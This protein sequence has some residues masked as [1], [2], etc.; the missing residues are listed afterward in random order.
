MTARAIIKKINWPDIGFFCVV[1]FILQ[2][3]SVFGQS[4]SFIVSQFS[5]NEYHAG[6]QNWSVDVD[7]QGFVYVGNNDGLLV[8]N[9][10][11]WE[12]YQ[13]PGQSIVR[14]VYA[15]PDGRVYVGSYEEFG[16]WK[17][18]SIEGMKYHSLK[19]LLDNYTFHNEE[20]WKIVQLDDLIYFQ[21]FSS[22]FVYDG[23]SVENLTIPGNLIFLL[24][25]RGHLYV[26]AVDGNLYEL[27]NNHFVLFDDKGVLKGTEVKTVLPFESDKL[28]IGTTSNGVFLY[29]G[30]NISEWNVP[31]NES[32]KDFQI[33][34]AVVIGNQL[35][36]GTIVDGLYILDEKGQIKEHLN[37]EN[38]LQNNTILA[39]CNDRFGNLWLGLDSGIDQVSFNNPIE[40]YLGKGEQLGAVYTAALS[41]DKLY[42][43]T[44]RGIF[45]Y[46]NTGGKYHFDRFLD[47]SQ[48]Q[49]WQ[50]KNIDGFL[51]VGH[52]SGTFIIKNNKLKKIS[53]I[54]GGYSIRKMI[55][56]GEQ[57]L[58]QSTYTS[59]VIYHKTYKGWEFR[60]QV[61]GF[62]EP[63]RFIEV[64]HLGNLWI[65][66]NVKGLYR[67]NLNANLDSV[68]TQSYYSHQ[69]GLPTDFYLH[70]FK[71]HHRVVFTTGEK[72]F[73]WDDIES[74][75]IPFDELNKGLGRFQAGSMIVPVSENRYWFILKNEAA[76]FEI[77]DYQAKFI[78]QMM[79]P[80]Y[81]VDLVDG[82]ENLVPISDEQSLICLENGFALINNKGIEINRED[83]LHVVFR[84]LYAWNAANDNKRIL[85]VEKQRR[86]LPHFWNNVYFSFST[87]ENP[88][89][90]RLFQYK[91]EGL[92]TD[93]SG[94]SERKEIEYT[95]L[96]K[97]DYR[98]LV[99]TFN[100]HGI[101]NVPI[102]FKFTVLPIWYASTLAYGFYFLAGLLIIVL[103]QYFFRK[104]INRQHLRIQLEADSK[105]E[106]ERQQAIQEIISLQ[107][108]NLHTEISHKNIQLA[109]A[110]ISIIRKNELLIEIKKE[111]EKQ[112]NTLASKYPGRYFEKIT[113]LINKN[114][115]SDH[116]WQ[117]FEALFDQAHQ[118]FFMRL[119]QAHPELTQSDL[120][121]CAYLKLNLSSKEIA[122]LLNITNRGVEIRRYRLRKRLGLNVNQNLVEFIMQF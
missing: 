36:F 103:S 120:K 66:H 65:G 119:K 58:I 68:R 79:L 101:L 32:L 97:G 21:S 59:L 108:K 26:Q 35:A 2:F 117:M 57:Y 78:Y 87:S 3:A 4:S 110:T 48:G 13:Y 28:L 71:I 89:A 111:L 53:D 43:G 54:S 100:A 70:V 27:I 39:M 49:V 77:N 64:D 15:A 56:N 5:K 42:V 69:N 81:H 104:R 60:N 55:V 41:G 46:K 33:N 92:D 115:S 112:K 30:K 45:I 80:V 24:K 19:K 109:D 118:N 25:A 107:N 88:C 102:Q 52:T 61:V 95:R 20:I 76:L 74:R 90:C 34:N 14:S 7:D 72:L 94:W 75:L 82:Y 8:F 47:E 93:W 23:T 96:P 29:D 105:R 12:L 122:P 6:S 44:N 11:K 62:I 31:A 116:D 85:N 86:T 1:L 106:L 91:L 9:G 63:S 50:I 10:V 38:A 18:D 99:R 121:L 98:F 51:F 37:N 83:S 84:E 22:L 113:S 67:L 17:N 114:I 16:F 73:T 40:I